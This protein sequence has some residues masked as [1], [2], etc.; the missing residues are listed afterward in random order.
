[1]SSLTIIDCYLQILAE[2]LTNFTD[3]NIHKTDI[4]TDIVLLLLIIKHT[5]INIYDIIQLPA[6]GIVICIR[7]ST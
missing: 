7:S 6:I 5:D 1:M 2:I 3:T 4:D